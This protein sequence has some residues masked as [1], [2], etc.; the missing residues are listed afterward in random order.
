MNSFK[1]INSKQA[2]ILADAYAQG[3]ITQLSGIHAD[4]EKREV[5]ITQTIQ[6]AEV[7]VLPGAKLAIHGKGIDIIINAN[8]ELFDGGKIDLDK[9]PLGDD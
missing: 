4:G 2:R 8:I 9:L 3:M 5:T 1:Q 6:D 7:V